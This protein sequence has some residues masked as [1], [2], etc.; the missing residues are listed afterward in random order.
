VLSTRTA[1]E[2]GMNRVQNKNEAASGD[3]VA[4]RPGT[5]GVAE[6]HRPRSVLFSAMKNEAPFLLEW[7]AYHKAIGFDEIVI[8]SNP[9][10]DGMEEILA[11]L[12]EAGEIR[13]LRVVVPA[14]GAS[15]QCLAVAQFDKDV[16]YRDGNWHLW[17]DA[18]EF[19]NVHTGDRTVEA[20]VHAM[21]SRTCALLNWRVF[22]SAGNAKFPGRFIAPAFCRAARPAYSGNYQV[23]AFFRKSPAYRGFSG[24]GVHRPLLAP[25]VPLLPDE[26]IT[27]NG[28]VP[29]RASRRH[30]RWLKGAEVER[31][32]RVSATEFGWAL[33]QINHYIVRTPEFFDLKRSRGRGAAPVGS[34][35]SHKRHVPSFFKIHDRNE[36][37]DRSI[38]VWQDRVT[39]EIDRLLQVP[40]VAVAKAASD[41]LVA[42]ILS[43]QNLQPVSAPVSPPV[44]AGMAADA[45]IPAAVADLPTLIVAA[46]THRPR[47]VLFS[48]MKNEA[49]F[50]LEWIAY[51]KA[52]GFDE[53]VICSNPSNDGM[54]EILAALAEAGEIRHLRVVVPAGSRPQAEAA[55]AFRR[56]VGHREGDWYLWIDA[57]EFLNVH[58]GDRT[59]GA[60]IAA[61]GEKQCLMVNWR[62]FGSGGNPRFGGRV[63]A[64]AFM[65]AAVADFA[66]NAEVK[67]LFRFSAAFAGFADQGIH[68]PLVAR[69]SRLTP[70]DVVT[71]S[72]GPPSTDFRPHRTW[73]AGADSRGT[74]WV[75]SEEFGWNLAQIN[76]YLVRTPEFFALKKAR[77]RGFQADSLDDANLRHTAEFFQ[78]HDRNEEEDRSILVWEDRVT[79][80][81]ARLTALPGVA[82]AVARSAA[83]VAELLAET[84]PIGLTMPTS[85]LEPARSVEPAP[86]LPAAKAPAPAFALTFPQS[87][88]DLVRKSYAAARSILEY[89]SGGSTVLAAELGKPVISVESDQAWA[90]RLSAHLAGIAP[91]ARVHHV[92]IGP[93][94]KWGM[95]S[96]P[97]FHG[98]FHRYP[99]SV[100][101]RP[102][103]G[104]PD[105]VLIDGRFRAACLAAVMLRAQRPTTV[106]F[107]DYEDRS[108]YAGVEKLARKDAT[109]G[110][111]A[112]FTVVP[113]AIPPEMLT[114]VIGWFADPR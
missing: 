9:S 106:L 19:L 44:E 16:G 60:L 114:E 85:S 42:E 61:L 45:P 50:L 40:G 68:R 72:G 14:D 94:E 76:H 73:F 105:L 4:I 35:A 81:I 90:E 26:I 59:V 54:E 62:V 18:D 20:L 64:P 109:V 77:G 65:R 27:G 69:R 92:D 104:E 23:K 88:A 70:Q 53:I 41:R 5:Y 93:T 91:D 52:I 3:N 57:D 15:P 17:L 36:E 49:P 79:A 96:R 43:L 84:A 34:D 21:S 99:L 55:K 33:A 58:A 100:W 29:N 97:R 75:P 25:G 86:D 102:D 103:I 39:V 30:R 78:K 1:R 48:A 31:I 47:S 11:A 51:H 13:H 7:I 63:V 56:Q 89:G 2:Y 107:D 87:E 112:R 113:G 8:C 110:R 108:Y 101:D 98:R 95:P 111:M 67:S 74:F 46:E 37:E 32:A 22:G 12:A 71:G 80:G 83:L 10:N 6:T 28:G 66:T 24:L 38:L 82:E